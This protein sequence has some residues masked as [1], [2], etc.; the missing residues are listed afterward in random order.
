VGLTALGVLLDKGLDGA[1][2]GLVEPLGR[3]A[4]ASGAEALVVHGMLQEVVLPTKDV[5]AVLSVAS[6][7]LLGVSAGTASLVEFPVDCWSEEI[8]ES[9]THGSPVDRTKGCEPSSG[10]SALLLNLVVS[11]TI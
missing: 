10:H 2:V 6:P 5:I 7:V 9:A 3:K 4:V 1:L 8:E 11:Q